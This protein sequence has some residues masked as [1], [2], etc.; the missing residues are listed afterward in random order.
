MDAEKPPPP[1]SCLSFAWKNYWLYITA[2]L[3]GGGGAPVRI[4]GVK[5]GLLGEGQC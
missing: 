4:E 3:A 5:R 2:G 1:A